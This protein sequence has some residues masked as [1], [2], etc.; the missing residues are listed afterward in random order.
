MRNFWGGQL[1]NRQHDMLC[2]IARE[3]VTAGGSA[4]AQDEINTVTSQTATE[5]A[6][7]CADAWCL[8]TA[9]GASDESHMEAEGYEV[10]DL[11]EAFA[12]VMPKIK[13]AAEAYLAERAADEA[14]D[15]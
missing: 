15:R 7:E 2:A 11:A 1:Y 12:D 8:S 5:L 10:A 4:S 3:W 13:A 6:A 9:R 14:D